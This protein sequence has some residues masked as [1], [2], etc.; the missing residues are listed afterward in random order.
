MRKDW[1]AVARAVAPDIPADAVERYVAPLDG[2]ES[3][4]RP[5]ARSLDLDTLPA[6]VLL[7]AREAEGE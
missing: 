5:L 2:L 1:S 7:V 4:F 6:H 3:S